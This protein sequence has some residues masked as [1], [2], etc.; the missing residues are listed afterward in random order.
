MLARD[1]PLFKRGDR[2][3]LIHCSSPRIHVDTS[4]ALIK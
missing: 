2:G 4:V 3:T 1:N